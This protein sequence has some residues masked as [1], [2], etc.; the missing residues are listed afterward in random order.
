LFWRAFD[1]AGLL[2]GTALKLILLTGQRPGEVTHMHRDHIIDGWWTLPG[3]PVPSLGW[4]GT[5]NGQSHRVWLSKPAQE[6]L[7]ELDGEGPVF[8][9]MR[10]SDAMKAI[11]AKLKVERATPHDLRRSPDRARLRHTEGRTVS[12]HWSCI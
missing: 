2:A 6:L 5:K 1:D 4:P 9:S 11:C 8:S 3:A 12:R 10:V 7:A